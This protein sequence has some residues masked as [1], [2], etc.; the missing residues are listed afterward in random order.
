[1]A[2][3]G[4]PLPSGVSLRLEPSQGG[5]FRL[6]PSCLGCPNAVSQPVSS[7]K[8]IGL[9]GRCCVSDQGR[10]AESFFY[11]FFLLLFKSFFLLTYFGGGGGWGGSTEKELCAFMGAATAPLS[12]S[13]KF[14][15]D[16]RE[17]QGI[18]HVDEVG[19]GG[20]KGKDCLYLDVNRGGETWL[21]L[22][23]GFICMEV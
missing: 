8:P 23:R 4:L 12:E 18:S 9:P 14:G 21:G 5:S 7:T 6:G 3:G 11:C 13:F 19:D 1:M 16:I 20:G 17:G 22:A 2:S 10:V 15:R